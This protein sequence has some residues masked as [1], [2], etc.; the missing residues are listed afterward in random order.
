MAIVTLT[1]D[2][3]KDDYYVGALKGSI[4]SRCPD[5]TLV[6]ISHQV[7]VFNIAHAAFLIRNSYRHFPDQTVHV[8]AVKCSDDKGHPFV[9]VQYNKHYFI[10]T[11]NGIFGLI[12][13]EGPV[14]SVRLESGKNGSFREC[15]VLANAACDIILKK[16]I[17]LIGKQYHELYRQLPILPAIDEGRIIGS[18]VYVDSYQNAITNISKSL[19]EQIGKGR[20]FEIQG[21]HFRI[22]KINSSYHETSSGEILA[23]FNSL[24]LLE[25]AMNEGNAADLLNLDVTSSVR[26]RFLDPPVKAKHKK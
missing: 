5:T 14:E 24:D 9:A 7:P 4:L 1:S 12:L 15:S 16:K 25:I 10:G 13:D 3:N 19:F 17:S 22:Q 20:S 23:L 6:D 18:V 21:N 11:D 8:I 26:I 2:W